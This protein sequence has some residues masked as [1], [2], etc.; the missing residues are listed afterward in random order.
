MSIPILDTYFKSILDLDLQTSKI[1]N[2][3][4]N[5][6]VENFKAAHEGRDLYYDCPHDKF[7]KI[8]TNFDRSACASSLQITN[9]RFWGDFIIAESENT[10][11]ILNNTSKDEV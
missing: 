7:L 1:E 2:P 8:I 11:N 5:M 4:I 3:G 9:E 10:A 6:M